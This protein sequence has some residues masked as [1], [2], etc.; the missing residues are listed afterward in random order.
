V[1]V[2]SLLFALLLGTAVFQQFRFDY[3]TL[4]NLKRISVDLHAYNE[5]YGRFP[6][7]FTTNE[8][9]DKLHSWRAL[10]TEFSDHELWTQI[11]F[12]EPWNS[13]ANQKLWKRVPQVLTPPSRECNLLDTGSTYYMIC[14]AA[15]ISVG[16]Q[17]ARFSEI[18]HPDRTVLVIE[19]PQ[20]CV[21]WMEPL[22]V[23]IDE[24]STWLLK[25][26]SMSWYRP[27]VGFADASVNYVNDY[28]TNEITEMLKLGVR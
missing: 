16:T 18:A 23:T 5:K 4:S 15:A 26:S 24:V 21:N 19:I 12:D 20:R 25:R 13:P 8:K 28:T 6:P 17:S 22:D 9:G 14:D 7:S 11:R 10:V 27:G 1:I 2:A 3:R